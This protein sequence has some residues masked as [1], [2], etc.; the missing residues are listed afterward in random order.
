MSNSNS[1]KAN[2]KK[3]ISVGKKTPIKK[4]VSHRLSP[5]VDRSINRLANSDDVKYVAVMPD[6]HLATDVCIGT[7]VATESIVYPMAIGGDIGCGILSIELDAL[8]SR[9]NDKNEAG[10]LLDG[11]YRFVP[12]NRH[13]SASAPIQLPAELVDWE[14][15]DSKLEKMKVRDARV[16]LGTLGRGNHFL[17]FQS[18]EDGKL[19]LMIHSGSR[20]M[21]QAITAHH[22]ASCEAAGKQMIGLDTAKSSGE[23]YLNDMDWAR[24]YAE[25]N[26]LSMLNATLRL[27]Q[28]WSIQPDWNSLVHTD[29]NHVQREI[30]FGE[31][32]LVH[33]KG[34]Q[35]LESGELGL[36][37]GSMATSSFVVAGRG[38]AN[39]LSSCS[40]GA[41]RKLSRTEAKRKV[42]SER[43]V[44]QMQHVWFDHR[45]SKLLRDEA[46]EAYKD[47]RE[48]MRSQKALV[49]I[50]SK[51]QPILS[52]KGS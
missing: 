1:Y 7:V 50:V 22:L 37:P 19:C 32:W 26:R 39:A 48:V 11:L 47:V 36:V 8:A 44:S 41:G 4:W 5:E 52:F 29:H 17:E 15:T 34:A 6:V 27:L 38:C 2:P 16:Q 12:R 35:R 43:L 25:H 18:N 3:R 30:H 45:K 28:K 9:F 40:H 23:D 14:L 10:K 33:R 51:R 13:P 49:K 31:S 42:S 20:S 21:G 24:R 46:P